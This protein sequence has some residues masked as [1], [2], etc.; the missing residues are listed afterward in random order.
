MVSFIDVLGFRD[1]LKTRSAA[2]VYGVVKKLEHFTKPE[3]DNP[4]RSIAEIRMQSRAFAYALSDAIIRVRPYDTQYH[5]GAFFWELY[6]LLHAQIALINSGVLM[7]AGVA[8]GDG[9]VGLNGEGP[10]FGPAMV[11]AFEIES[12]EAIFPRVVIDEHAIE[13]HRTDPRLRGEHNT[14]DYELDVV[15]GFLRTGEDGT[16]F[17]DYLRACRTEF[18]EL[19]SYFRFLKRHADL[20][21]RGRARTE[22]R[23]IL[24]KYDWLARYH[25]GCTAELLMEAVSSTHLENALYEEEGLRVDMKAYIEGL[26]VLSGR[27]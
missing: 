21:R 12:Q 17:I 27:C 1:L 8:V 10:I 22:E 3:E 11:R 16:R 20:I 9:Y 19:S 14:L 26:R 25:D 15:A 7:R 13:E 24:R 6:D 23:R 5:D 4:P 18:E 2:E